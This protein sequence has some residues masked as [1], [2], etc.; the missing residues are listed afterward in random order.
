MLA[1]STADSDLAPI[2]ELLRSYIPPLVIDKLV[3]IKAVVVEASADV[4]RNANF[5]CYAC[6][7]VNI[8]IAELKGVAVVWAKHFLVL[9]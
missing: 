7:V 6:S 1:L 3:T 2:F 5:L 8:S 9:F 4:F